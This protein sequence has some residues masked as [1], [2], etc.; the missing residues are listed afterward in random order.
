[1]KKELTEKQRL[2]ELSIYTIIHN[3]ANNEITVEYER[4]D[5]RFT[6]DKFYYKNKLV[7]L[8]RKGVFYITEFHNGGT[9]GNDVSIWNLK[10]AV[11]SECYQ[12]SNIPDFDSLTEQQQ[13]NFIQEQFLWENKNRLNV[14]SYWKEVIENNRILGLYD[15]VNLEINF[16]LYLHWGKLFSKKVVEQALEKPIVFETVYKKYKGWG[17]S[18]EYLQELKFSQFNIKQLCSDDAITLKLFFTDEQIELLKLKRFL[19]SNCRTQEIVKSRYRWTTVTS[20][21]VSLKDAKKIWFSEKKEE[22]KSG[23]LKVNEEKRKQIEKEQ[24]KRK[25][26]VVKKELLSVEQFRL[27]P[28][29]SIHNVNYTVLFYDGN[30]IKSSLGMQIQIEEAKKALRLFRI[31]ET[32]HALI[33][34]FV[35]KG[36][37][38]KAI[39]YLNDEKE[40]DYREEDCL[41]VGCHVIPE[42]EINNFLSFYNLNW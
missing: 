32:K 28:H 17:S 3:W 9:R 37:V 4:K 39:P 30:M 26:E 6:P 5:Y 38:K 8:Y 12:I 35:Y 7:G 24:L 27:N 16:P 41:V 25:E 19:Y 14:I 31:R 33:Q 34:G 2:N 15:S 23:I 13:I 42:S 29:V 10:R 1:M 21:S 20:Y 11:H 22:W 36:V 18:C 40:V